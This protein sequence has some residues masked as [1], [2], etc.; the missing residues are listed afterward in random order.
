[1]KNRFFG[2][3]KLAMAIVA[4]AATITACTTT[5]QAQITALATNAVAKAGQACQFIQPT[6]V[7]L[8]TA[9]PN[10]ANVATL[11]TD[12]AALCKAFAALDP[13]NGA[14]LINT[15]IPQAMT[16]VDLIP[17][18]SD[19]KST[20]KILLVAASAAIT[21]WLVVVSPQSVK[22]P[23]NVTATTSTTS[24]L[25]PAMQGREP[26]FALV[27]PRTIKLGRFDTVDY[28]TADIRPTGSK[29]AGAVAFR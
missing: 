12:N 8:Q 6:L 21:N 17:I 18:N 10:D 22:A 2:L 23:A 1:M 7:T 19:Q 4:G 9:M 28:V 13:T 25:P 16:I 11:V 20:I 3:L 27:N 5:Q 26:A 24:M 14:T 15:L 29:F